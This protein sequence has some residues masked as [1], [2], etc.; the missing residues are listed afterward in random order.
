M[1][2]K[3][4][5]KS[6]RR[7]QRIIKW[8]DSITDLMNTNLNKLWERVEDRGAWCAAVHRARVRPDLVTKQQ[9]INLKKKK[10]LTLELNYI[11][12]PST[13]LYNVN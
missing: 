9:Q 6:R 5:G 3:I 10:K 4:E 13:F 8:L 12:N 1:L 7:W 11:T 2:G